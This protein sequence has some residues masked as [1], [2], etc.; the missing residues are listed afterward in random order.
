VRCGPGVHRARLEL[1]KGEQRDLGAQALLARGE[2]QHLQE[3]TLAHH[4][5]AMPGIGL[6]QQTARATVEKEGDLARGLEVHQPGLQVVRMR[7]EDRV[8]QDPAPYI[9]LIGRR[10]LPGLKRLGG[11]LAGAPRQPERRRRGC[12]DHAAAGDAQKGT[13]LHLWTSSLVTHAS[14]LPYNNEQPAA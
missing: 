3:G 6:R 12:R 9:G 1:A 2:F 4:H 14:V 5:L 8:G 13:T 11:Q 7:G 10:A